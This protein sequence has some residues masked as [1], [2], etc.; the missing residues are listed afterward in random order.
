MLLKQNG[1][2]LMSVLLLSTMLLGGCVGTNNRI[3]SGCPQIK[4]APV[5]VIEKLSELEK[6]RESAQ[7]V[8]DLAKTKE[9]LKECR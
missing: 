8:Q 6:D 7:W 1:K 9:K 4:D 3:L 5:R 2:A